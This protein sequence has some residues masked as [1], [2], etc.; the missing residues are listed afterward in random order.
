MTMMFHPHRTSVFWTLLVLAPVSSLAFS[1][2]TTT[3]TTVSRR[4][5]L[6]RLDRQASHSSSLLEREHHH[7]QE[8]PSSLMA[9]VME[10]SFYPINETS[11]FS[12][13]NEYAAILLNEKDYP[14]GSLP[15][16]VMTSALK[17]LSEWRKIETVQAAEMVEQMMERLEKENERL[18][19]HRH[20]TVAARAWATSGHENAAR[21]AERILE[22]MEYLAATSNPSVAPSYE[23]YRILLNAYTHQNKPYRAEAMLRKME[24]KTNKL[25]SFGDYNELLSAFARLGN[26]RKAEEILKRLVDLCKETKSAEYAPDMYMYQRVLAA[27]ASSNDPIAGQRAKQIL[28]MLMELSDHGELSF[29]PDERAYSAV[30]SAI[31]RSNDV[32]RL[33][34]AQELF[35]QA[36]ARG[37]APNCYMYVAMM[38]AYAN[39]GAVNKTEEILRRMDEE[40]I[41]NTVAYNSVLKAW[42]SSSA[43]DAPERAEAILEQMITLGLANRISFTTVMAAYGNRGNLDSA[44]KADSLLRRMQDLYNNGDLSDQSIK[45]NLKSYNTSKMT[46]QHDSLFGARLP[47]ALTSL[48]FFFSFF[49]I[50]VLNSWVQCGEVVRAEELLETME[51]LFQTGNLTLPPNVVSF[52]TVINGWWKSRKQIAPARAERLF[53]RMTDLYKAGNKSAKPNHVSY[54]NLINA[55]ARSRHDDAPQRAE[56]ILYEMYDMYKAGNTDV[57]P[58]TRLVCMVMDCWQKSGKQNAGLK[59]EALLDWLTGLYEQHQDKDFEPNQFVYSSGTLAPRALGVCGSLASDGA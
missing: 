5:L 38:Q 15:Q 33:E 44:L 6:A 58:N 40:G 29:Q 28:E 52:T 39:I 46:V 2:S 54:V 14:I 57:K 8:E 51:Q 11:S 45:P 9:A 3:T 56:D 31:V 4:E 10:P 49:F 18:L 48:L 55:I 12:E 20:Y 43:P 1:F 19:D 27:W 13:A 41:A 47:A 42:K 34:Q 32:D 23:T 17:I 22:R 30:I 24:E 35:Q 59:A 53:K 37:I 21:N 16:D 25:P 7:V 26:A 50:K 36:L